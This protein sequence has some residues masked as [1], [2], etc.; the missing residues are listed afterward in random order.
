MSRNPFTPAFGSEPMFLAGRQEI[1]DDIIDGLKNGPGDP[2]RSS[3][4][5]GPR[6]SGKTVL[7]SKISEEAEKI[8][9]ISAN[10]TAD[11][12]VL[13]NIIDQIQLNGSE[14]FNKKK[15]SAITGVQVSGVGITRDVLPEIKISWR[16][17][18][19]KLCD[20]ISKN[21]GGIIITVDE[22][23]ADYPEM[24]L[25][26]SNFQHFVREKREIV[27]IMAGLPGHVMQMLQDKD[28]SFLRRA[29]QHRLD[30]ISIPEV[31]ISLK[32]TIEMSG[33]KIPEAALDEAAKYT[34]GYPF[35][36]Q[37]IGYQAWK[38][39]GERKTIT[40]DDVSNGIVC[41]EGVMEKTIFDTIIKELSKK[42]IEFLLAMTKDEKVSNISDIA[43]RIGASPSLTSQYRKRLINQGLIAQFGRGRINFEMPFL[44]EYLMKYY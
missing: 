17:Q 15:K 9:W 8:G 19:V 7:L 23:K 16:T 24:I 44:K 5:I 31:K 18:M 22:V 13:D 36:I 30:P 2:N 6:G 43:G 42:D 37:L 35:L 34:G 11:N 41:S 26:V 14:I 29:F 3:I 25:L 32:K 27:L 40:I 21:G 33:K 20:E 4:L 12:C 38:E 39:A 28:I 1:I 10:V